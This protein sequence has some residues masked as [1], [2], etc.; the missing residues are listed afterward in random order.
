MRLV[1]ADTGPLNYLIQIGAVD[2]LAMLAEA[3]VIPFSIHLELLHARAPAA[4]REWA[5]KLPEWVSVQS[6][7]E[8]IR[9]RDISAADGEAIG[10]ALQLKAD[11]ILMDDRHA[12]QCAA[13]LGVTTMGTLGLLELAAGRGLISL[14][15][16]LEKLRTTSCYLTDELIDSALRRQEEKPQQ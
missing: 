3:T 10:L 12:R 2:L 11:L 8:S 9:E 6:A 13:R 4:V 15:D 1:V 5:L 7:V 14:R 16:V